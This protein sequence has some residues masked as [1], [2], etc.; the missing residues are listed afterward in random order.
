MTGLIYTSDVITQGVI[1]SLSSKDSIN[2]NSKHIYIKHKL[3]MIHVKK[4][5]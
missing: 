1:I 4:K 3:F 2:E 5:V